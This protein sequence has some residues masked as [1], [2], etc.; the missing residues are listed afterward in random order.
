MSFKEVSKAPTPSEIGNMKRRLR[1]LEKEYDDLRYQFKD[2]IDKEDFEVLS[3]DDF[4]KLKELYI[5]TKNL[6]WQIYV[7]ENPNDTATP[8][9]YKFLN[10]M[11]WN[12]Q[13]DFLASHG[14]ST[15]DLIE[16]IRENPNFIAEVTA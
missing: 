2:H 12:E 10:T 4:L 13:I 16:A 7:A 9:A 11:S 1:K 15:L 6:S 14:M 5:L 3:V 8:A